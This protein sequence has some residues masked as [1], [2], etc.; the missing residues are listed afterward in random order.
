MAFRPLLSRCHSK[1]EPLP[2]TEAPL[3][4]RLAPS[5]PPQIHGRPTGR[6]AGAADGFGITY[7]P[8]LNREAQSTLVSLALASAPQCPF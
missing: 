6:G 8:A 4:L 7:F 5:N 2:A 1:T 3:G